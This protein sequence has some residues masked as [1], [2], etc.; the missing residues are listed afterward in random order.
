MPVTPLTTL[1]TYSSALAAENCLAGTFRYDVT[2]GELQ[3]SEEIYLIHGYH[4]GEVVPTAG[5]MASH[6][7]PDDRLRCR[8]IFAE[9][10]RAGGVFASYHR[11][12]DA[13]RREHRVLVSGEGRPGVGGKPLFI[14]GFVMDLTRTLQL[15]TDRSARDAV[16]GAIG[17]RGL[18]EQAK[19]ILM[20]ILHIGSDAAFNLL[21]AYSQHHNIKIAHAAAAI[22]RLANNTHEAATLR[23]LVRA[24]ERRF[25]QSHDGERALHSG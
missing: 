1:L 23:S 6:Q 11:L 10:C 2:S 9:V 14:D 18:I 16:A 19:G 12:V 15:E 7:H 5:L 4:R 24:L 3:W 8:E 13:R 21:S 20:G 22:V 17:T 25:A